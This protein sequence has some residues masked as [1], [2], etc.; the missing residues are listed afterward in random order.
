MNEKGLR[1]REKRGRNQRG[2]KA[3]RNTGSK[4][5]ITTNYICMTSFEDE[6]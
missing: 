4:L 2:E 6:S 1:K 5:T 3:K